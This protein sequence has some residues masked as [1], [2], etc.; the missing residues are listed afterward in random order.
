VK[1]L[2]YIDTA[3]IAEHL[4]ISEAELC[5]LWCQQE[6]ASRAEE[7]RFKNLQP[8]HGDAVFSCAGIISQ[9]QRMAWHR[10][11]SNP[12]STVLETGPRPAL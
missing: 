1:I 6:K 4:G 7:R 8:S 12:R 3:K 9:D 5:D 11:E 10:K 2:H